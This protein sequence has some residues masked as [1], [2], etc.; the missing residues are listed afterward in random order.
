MTP[1]KTMSASVEEILKRP[2]WLADAVDKVCEQTAARNRIVFVQEGGE[3]FAIVPNT[4]RMESLRQF[5]TPTRITQA[6]ELREVASFASY[7]NR[8]KQDSTVIF[9]TLSEF[10]AEFKAVLDYHAA[11]PSLQPGRCEHVARFTT[12]K[13]PEWESWLAVN[14][15]PMDQVAF[16]TFVEENLKMFITPKGESIPSGAEL[17]ELVT[18]IE[19][20]SNARFKQAVRLQSGARRVAYEEEVIVKGQA[21]VDSG[22]VDL[23][24][25]VCVAIAPFYGSP[26]Y[27]VRARLKFTVNGAKLMLYLETIALPAI[28][29]DNIELLVKEV[30]EK[31]GVTPYLGKT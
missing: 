1:E 14:R 4:M 25:L 31:T 8:F 5:L 2:T 11:G 9:V 12:V 15:K 10:G 6:V 27:E 20:H 28:V 30:V 13:T 7:V 24:P 29:R 22:F 19:G 26:T 3:P 21:S 17:L 18:S 23:P 16:A